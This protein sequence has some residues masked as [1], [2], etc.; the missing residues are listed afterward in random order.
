MKQCKII[1]LCWTKYFSA[2]LTQSLIFIFLKLVQNCPKK[3]IFLVFWVIEVKEIA[4]DEQLGTVEI[5]GWAKKARKKRPISK[6]LHRGPSKGVNEGYDLFLLNFEPKM[7][8]F[9]LFLVVEVQNQMKIPWNL[10]TIKLHFW[11][12]FQPYPKILGAQKWPK[13]AYLEVFL[14]H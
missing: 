8:I 7:T 6:F 4:R 14:S 12:Q 3:L 1:W 10:G 11:I 2:I 13:I 9:W 5:Y